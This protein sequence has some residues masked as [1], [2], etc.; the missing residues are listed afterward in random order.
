MLPRATLI[1]A[2]IAMCPRCNAVQN[3]PDAQ[4]AFECWQCKLVSNV[5]GAG[6]VAGR[7]GPDKPEDTREW[8][9]RTTGQ[10]ESE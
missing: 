7:R 4:T 1:A 5:A 10:P 6:Y 8:F 2:A 9:N 3:I